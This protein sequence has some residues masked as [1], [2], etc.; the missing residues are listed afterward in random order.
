MSWGLSS[1]MR[2]H[3]AMLA[4]SG[5]VAGSYSLGGQVANDV[6]PIAFTAVRF[7]LASVVVG[8]LAMAWSRP[9]AQDFRAPWRYGIM[10]GLLVTYFVLMFEALRF[11]DPVSTS[12]VFTLTPL[13]SALF[14][15]ILLRQIT[16]SY[17]ALAL[18]VGGAGALWVIFRADFQALLAFRIGLGERI[19]FVG[20]AAHALYT[21]LVRVLNRGEALPVFTFGILTAG[22]VL[23]WVLGWPQ[24]RATD[25]TN[26]PPLVWITLGYTAIMASVLTF[27]LLQFAA[28]RLPS[29]KVMAYTYLT[30]CW[31]ILW[32]IGLSGG[33]VEV[34]VLWGVA[35]TVLALLML[36][37][38]RQ[39]VPDQPGT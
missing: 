16:S 33:L 31:V 29:G 19:F 15:W 24:I 1:Q 34:Q 26:L 5:V 7:L 38:D 22:T 4:F 35:L 14:G 3:L 18:G 20:C 10:G 6:A 11:A 30:P 39:R 25:W 9:K 36:L 37:G 17:V 12:A 21:P 23:L 32:E 27:I 2:G 8:V 13:M 28:L